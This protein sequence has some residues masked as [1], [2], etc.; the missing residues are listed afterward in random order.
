[1]ANLSI[2]ASNNA[3][4][5]LA[6]GISS[7]ATSLTVS[8]GTGSA[9][10]TP[11]AGQS[12]FKLTLIDAATESI[13]EIVHVTARSGDNFTIV[14]GREGTA[15]RSWSVSDLAVNMVTAGTIAAMAQYGTTEFINATAGRLINTQYFRTAGSFTY[16]PTAG[17]RMVKVISTGGGGSGGGCQAGSTSQTFAGA[18][19]G[20]GGTAIKTLLIDPTATY[21]GFIGD[22]GAAVNGP[23]SG[24][25]GQASS[26]LGVTAPGGDGGSKSS[27]TSTPGGGGGSP[28]AGD[29]NIVG[30]SG[31]DGQI[32]A[33]LL[34]GNGGASYWGGGGRA[35][36][37]GGI[38]GYAFGSGGGGAYDSAF[39]G[40]PMTS[41]AGRAGLIVVEEYA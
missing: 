40:S 16:T 10:P 33:F 3:S 12:Y 7:T 39:T 25:A 2:I 37:G 21:P 19:G 38:Q 23:G 28:T 34:G 9:F 20:A 32:G 36:N 29:L 27:N 31:T 30:G 24:N 11:V 26:M 5:F 8:S 22:G 35:G 14:R 18:G 17:T 41:G 4:S 13:N 1:M 15:A 6:S